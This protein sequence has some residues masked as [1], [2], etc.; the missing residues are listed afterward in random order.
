MWNPNCIHFHN[1]NT[2]LKTATSLNTNVSKVK[3]N[4]NFFLSYEEGL[5]KKVDYLLTLLARDYVSAC[6]E[7]A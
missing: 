7:G 2:K 4:L 5:Q 6:T 1:I 3:G